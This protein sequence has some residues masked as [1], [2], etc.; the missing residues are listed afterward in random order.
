M[1]SKPVHTAIR[2]ALIAGA[3]AMLT[4]PAATIAQAQNDQGD[5]VETVV[6]T[7]SRILGSNLESPSPIQTVTAEDIQTSGVPNIQDLL[8]KSPVFGTPLSRTNSNFLTSS[9]GVATIDL[10]NLGTARTLVLVDGRRF[11]AGIPGESA[12][13][14]NTIPASFIDRVDVMTGGASSIYGSD[15]IAGVVNIIYKKNFE[16]FSFDAQYGE[17]AEGDGDETQLGATFGVSSADG[18]GNVMGYIGYTDQ[19]SVLSRDRSRSAVDQ[20]STALLTGDPAD[21][22]TPQRP[23]YSSYA[24]QGR[25]FTANGPGSGITFDANGNVIPWSTNG[26][27][28][29]AATGFNRSAFRTI[30]VPIERYLFASRGNYEFA[31][32]HRAF[33]EGTYASTQATSVLEPYPLGA[34]DIYPATGGQTPAEFLV[35]GVLLA[36]PLIPAAVFNTT[37]DEDGD[38][39]RDYYFTRRMAEAGNRGSV[40]DRDTFRIV[41]GLEG[42]LFGGGWRYEAF[43]AYGQT[44]EAQ[45]SSG[46]VNV[47]NFRNA[48]EA[49][50]DVDDLDGDGNVTEAICRDANARAQGCVP[51][52]VFGFNSISPAAF[53]YIKAPGMLA[54]FTQQK[55]AGLNLTGHVFDLPAGPVGL[56]VGAEYRDEYSRS[57]FDPLQQAGLN[58]GN[59]IPRTEGDFDVK[60][61]YLEVRVPLLADKPMFEKLDINGAVRFADY[62]TVG[63]VVSWNGGLEWSPIPSLRFRAIRALA[64]RA[65]NINELFSP[66]SQDFPTGLQDPCV[67]VTATSTG[68]VDAACRAAPGVNANIAANGAFTLNQADIQGISG[69]NRG[70]PNLSEEEGDSWTVGVVIKPSDIPVLENFD[71]TLDYY[72]ID[73]K[74]AIVFTP[75]QFILDQCYRGN[76]ALCQFI[77]RRPAA[78]GAN[79]AGSLEFIDSGPTNSGG[80]FAE[81]IDL[82]VSYA[83]DIGP[84]AFRGRLAFTHVLDQYRV[85]LPGAAKD[86]IVGEVEDGLVAPE[87]RAVLNLGYTVGKFGATLTTTYLG[88]VALD[89]QF[90]AQFGEA[91]GSIGVG[92]KT[93]LDAQV[94]YSPTENYQIFVGANNL[95][96]EEPPPIISGLPG[97]DTGTETNAGAYDPIGRRWYAGV[98]VKL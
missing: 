56:A 19:G 73:I 85:P 68:D 96:D 84:G 3:A 78:V 86:Y 55:I 95:L 11:V 42:E 46:Q 7:G 75:R 13:D 44:K 93:Y 59:A 76:T 35:N 37:A 50:P 31:D 18:R 64:T 33:F 48:L 10:R 45:T 65:P 47:L 97:D 52:N 5:D 69:F 49:I 62:S 34:E 22:F 98:R 90:L 6:V 43:Y 58:A 20:I 27:S 17:S 36:N 51:I 28:T 67:G 23:F 40:A 61:G 9:V 91:R 14:L 4:L 92:S 79:S 41:G 87:N 30:A 54:T 63:S 70:N 12:V 29:L 24:P 2:R 39:L 88:K 74:D 80:E 94:T 25:F 82:T 38:G 53:D 81:G 8:V 60:E 77:T 71:L 21:M 1:Q 16:G 89:D 26:T 72:R 57:E 83:Q 66:P 32:H 15:A